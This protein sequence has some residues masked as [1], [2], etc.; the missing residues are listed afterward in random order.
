MYCYCY[1]STWYCSDWTWTNLVSY[2]NIRSRVI[3]GSIRLECDF[4]VSILNFCCCI[5]LD[6][7]L[8]LFLSVWSRIMN[9]RCCQRSNYKI[10]GCI[11]ICQVST[12]INVSIWTWLNSQFIVVKINSCRRRVLRL[13]HEQFPSGVNRTICCC[14][15]PFRRRVVQVKA[16]EVL[17]PS[18]QEKGVPTLRNLYWF[19][20][21]ST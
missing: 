9:Y 15:F 16:V 10:W 21:T 5:D 4:E 2:W 7:I 12:F 14:A 19:K 11:D 6:I 17:A 13:K 1:V 18:T 3:V 8:C 20:G